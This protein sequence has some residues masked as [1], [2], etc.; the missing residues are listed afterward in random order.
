MKP[1]TCFALFLG[2]L[3]VG[4][5]IFAGVLVWEGIHNPTKNVSN[6]PTLIAGLVASSMAC[7]G[8]VI[9]HDEITKL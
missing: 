5:F 7:I 6:N 3:I 2:G 1:R 9:L 8:V 4:M